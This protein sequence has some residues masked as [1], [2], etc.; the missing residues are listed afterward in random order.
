[1]INYR[2]TIL[3]LCLFINGCKEVKDSE[4]SLK[5]YNVEHAFDID[6][7]ELFIDSISSDVSI[8]HLETS[9]EILI[10]N[11]RKIYLFRDLLFVLHQSRC[12][13][14]DLK[15]K[16]LYDIGRQGQ[17]PGEYSFI[18]FLFFSDDNV[19]LY[20]MLQQRVFYYTIEGN[21]VNHCILFKYLNLIKEVRKDVFAGFVP[22]NMEDN[23]NRMIFFNK[24]GTIIDSVRHNEIF[25]EAKRNGSTLD[26]SLFTYNN[27]I[28]ICEE[29]NDTIFRI[30]KDLKFIPEYIITTGKYSVN[31]EDRKLDMDK[32]RKGKK[33]SVQFENDR[34]IISRR[35]GLFLS[36]T[37]YLLID[38]KRDKVETVMFTYNDEMN[39]L[40][41]DDERLILGGFE[42][43][44][45]G[46]NVETKGYE[47]FPQHFSISGVS[48][49]GMVVI[50]FE[51]LKEK[52]YDNPVIVMVRIKE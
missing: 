37:D 42:M 11:I 18:N 16:Y 41:E 27:N 36:R 15:G 7:K 1:M 44:K 4:S 35:S 28:Y 17:G 12:S 31:Y 14:F 19:C 23:D 49:D 26:G 50:G 2:F 21:Y 39:N 9:D 45:N 29:Y 3:L 24:E 47:T 5:C 46:M 52:S 40:F 38:K 34:Y 8:V 30:S 32:Y 22:V 10:M 43:T 33:I 6:T 13:V 48:E 51:T 20:D 25:P